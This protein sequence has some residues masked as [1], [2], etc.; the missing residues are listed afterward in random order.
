MNDKYY[1]IPNSDYHLELS[2]AYH[3]G[4]QSINGNPDPKGIYLHIDVVQLETNCVRRGIYHSLVPGMKTGK[5]TLL[6]LNRKNQRKLDLLQDNMP[7]DEIAEL[8]LAERYN[9]ALDLIYSS[10]AQILKG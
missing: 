10:A 2:I 1:P 6:K 4:G 9:L 5:I 8:W 7:F 3:A